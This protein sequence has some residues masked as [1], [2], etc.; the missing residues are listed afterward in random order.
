[1][2]RC[3]FCA[4]DLTQVNK[5]WSGPPKP[6]RAYVCD[7]CVVAAYRAQTE[8]DAPSPEDVSAPRMPG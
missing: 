3:S 7:L 6:D 2:I 8:S 4:N 1:M 5:M